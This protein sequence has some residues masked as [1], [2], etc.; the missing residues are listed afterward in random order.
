MYPNDPARRRREIVVAWAL[1]LIL[2][3]GIFGFFLLTTGGLF[4]A[5]LAGVVAMILVGSLHYVFWGRELA[6]EVRRRQDVPP[7]PPWRP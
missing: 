2:G 1:A 5:V 7:P 4:L 6:R 3:V